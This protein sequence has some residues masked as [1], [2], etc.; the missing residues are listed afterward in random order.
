M[1]DRIRGIRAYGIGALAL[2]LLALAG[3]R[4]RW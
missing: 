1:N 2:L 3:R 4:R